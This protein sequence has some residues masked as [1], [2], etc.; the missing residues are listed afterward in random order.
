MRILEYLNALFAK[1]PSRKVEKVRV[2]ET[3]IVV[4][5]KPDGRKEIRESR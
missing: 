2:G 1:E 4:V 5:E 3:V